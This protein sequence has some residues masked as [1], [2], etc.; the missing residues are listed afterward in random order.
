MG[1]LSYWIIFF[2]LFPALSY[3]EGHGYVL[4][5][6]DSATDAYFTITTTADY[7]VMQSTVAWQ[8]LQLVDLMQKDPTT[9]DIAS[10]WS[11]PLTIGCAKTLDAAGHLK[12]FEG[13]VVD[14]VAITSEILP[15]RAPLPEEYGQRKISTFKLT[16]LTGKKTHYDMYCVL[17]PTG[18][19]DIVQ[20][21][22]LGEVW[23]FSGDLTSTGHIGLT[24]PEML[25]FNANTG[26]KVSLNLPLELQYLDGAIDS[27]QGRITW[28]IA[29]G[30]DN[31]GD[32]MPVVKLNGA[33]V[34]N[35]DL[36]VGRDKQTITPTL[37]INDLSAGHW[38]W[39][40]TVT[41]SII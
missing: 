16:N 29:S 23:H 1:R 6:S 17:H 12:G 3:A 38:A 40:M 39:T 30:G 9:P 11:Q 13:L 35:I 20:S 15:A 2:L 7:A 10:D 33:E 31:P 21:D 19:K 41:A 28:T 24:A 34:N 36:T 22:L 26:E 37:E 27:L 25:T 18:S 4:A 8:G 32:A 14:G 5:V